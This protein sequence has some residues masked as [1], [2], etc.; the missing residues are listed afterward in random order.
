VPGKALTLL[1][2]RGN[3]FAKG[4]ILANF[5][6][7]RKAINGIAETLRSNTPCRGNA[8]A[9]QKQVNDCSPAPAKPWA[10]LR[11]KPGAEL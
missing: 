1:L 10:L 11:R 4:R 7:N 2:T 3:N 9:W 8:D 6:S 5:G